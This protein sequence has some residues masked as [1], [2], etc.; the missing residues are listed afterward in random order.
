MAFTLVALGI[1][2]GI[3]A[4]FLIAAAAKLLAG[5]SHTE[6]W[7]RSYSLLPRRAVPVCARL[8]PVGEALVGSVLLWGAFG[9]GG[10]ATAI[11]AL[12]GLT[13]IAGHALASRRQAD[14]GC[15]GRWSAPLSWRVVARN[16]AMI[17]ALAA[18]ITITPSPTGIA[19]WSV[20]QQ[21]GV[22]LA[23]AIALVVACRQY[24]QLRKR[25]Q[26]PRTATD[27]SHG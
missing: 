16:L 14:C 17:V 19:P 7:L 15:F 21:I 26:I 13:S 9:A 2:V 20:I 6:S 24:S 12:V 1:R 10:T 4:L 11:V 8:L 25:T 27:S 22:V 18:T 5:Q 3:A 23:T